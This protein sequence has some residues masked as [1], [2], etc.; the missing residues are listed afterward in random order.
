MEGVGRGGRPTSGPGLA[1][2]AA[3]L[4]ACTG[5]SDRLEELFNDARSSLQTGHLL[6]ALELTRKGKALAP[7]RADGDSW[8]FLLL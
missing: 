7:G 3:L 2:I 6:A 4:L 5:R 8:R 1:L